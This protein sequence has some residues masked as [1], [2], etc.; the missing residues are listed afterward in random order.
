MDLYTKTPKF[1][2]KP[3]E[4]LIL[5]LYQRVIENYEAREV[6]S[7]TNGKILLANRCIYDGYAYNTAYYNLGWITAEQKHYADHLTEVIFLKEF[8]Q[9]YAIVLNPPFEVVKQ[10]LEERW[11]MGKKKWNEEDM[12]YLQAACNAY[13][14]FKGQEKILYVED[15]TE[16][17]RKKIV[18]WLEG[19]FANGKEV[20]YGIEDHLRLY[21]TALYEICLNNAK[22]RYD[23]C[24]V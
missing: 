5:K 6:A 4:R 2:T 19:I 13:T 1:E 18:D 17:E 15:N 20:G 16:P 24:R 7:K 3:L 22:N 8:H 14:M 10:R 21:D 12:N 23:S 11:K 9:P